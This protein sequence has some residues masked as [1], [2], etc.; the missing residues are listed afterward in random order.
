MPKVTRRE[1]REAKAEFEAPG[2]S[3]GDNR[4]LLSFTA[5]SRDEKVPTN[6]T[7]EPNLDL[8]PGSCFVD[9][10]WLIPYVEFHFRT[11]LMFDEV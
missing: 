5:R 10:T 8:L 6:G 1:Q 7:R 9:D 4:M 11:G 2:C 3:S